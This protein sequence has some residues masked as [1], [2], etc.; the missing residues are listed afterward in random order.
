MVKWRLA[1][2][3]VSDGGAEV[4]KPGSYHSAAPRGMLQ[5][6]ATMPSPTCLPSSHAV[7]CCSLKFH[8]LKQEHPSMGAQEA[9]RLAKQ[10]VR[11]PLRL[12]V[13]AR[14]CRVGRAWGAHACV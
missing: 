11:C 9:L 8:D 13:P 6:P 10:A 12:P 1:R 2:K 4:V 14:G 5:Q 3:R 7:P